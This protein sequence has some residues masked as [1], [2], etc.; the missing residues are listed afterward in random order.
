MNILLFLA[1]YNEDRGIRPRILKV[2]TVSDLM[3]EIAKGKESLSQLA[4]QGN[5]R[6]ATAQDMGKVYSRNFAQERFFSRNWP[7]KRSK[8]NQSAEFLVTDKPEFPGKTQ[9]GHKYL[10]AE[11]L[12]GAGRLGARGLKAT[13]TARRSQKRSQ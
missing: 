12:G 11:I 6:A 9:G 2:T 13:G 1:D 3:D 4:T 10:K 8:K 7:R 5:Y